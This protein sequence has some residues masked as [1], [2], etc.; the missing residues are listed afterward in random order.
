MSDQFTIGLVS[1]AF[2][3]MTFLAAGMA[4]FLVLSTI[5]DQYQGRYPGA[6]SP[7]VVAQMSEQ[8]TLTR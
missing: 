6:V 3:L 7:V 2:G 8:G 5:E 1:T 4:G